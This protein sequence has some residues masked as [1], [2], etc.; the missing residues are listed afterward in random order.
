[1]AAEGSADLISVSLQ[2]DFG[3]GLDISVGYAYTDAED[4]MPMTSFTA[5]SSF[6]NMATSDINFPAPAVSNY[7]VPHRFT[8]RVSYA[9]EFFGDLTTRFTAYGYL[10][11]GQPQSYT[12]DFGLEGAGPRSGRFLL[13]VPTGPSDPNVIFDP[14]FDQDA[15][16]A[17]VQRAGLPPGIQAR[18]AQHAPWSNRLDVRIDQ[19]IPTFFE[20][21]RGRLFI[22]VYNF[23]NFLSREWGNIVDAQ[24]FSREIVTGDME[25]VPA[26]EDPL[27][28][29]RR[30]I[31]EDFRARD[32][33]E[34]REN[35]SLWEARLG[36]DIY[37]GE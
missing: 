21:T 29:P 5:G 24:F 31:F 34:L 14:G 4:V 17:F 10:N 18:N 11:E 8:F 2:K 13:Y 20:G 12:M 15:F 30:Y 23:G 26:G 33:A 1:S 19:E 28:Y 22:K 25:S 6:E 35:R 36:I 3:N 7:V 32:I 27:T 16:F 9:R 37:F